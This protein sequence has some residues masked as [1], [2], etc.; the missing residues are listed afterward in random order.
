MTD[1][2]FTAKVEIFLH[3]RRH[4]G[5]E[6]TFASHFVEP[7]DFAPKQTGERVFFGIAT[8]KNVWLPHRHVELSAANPDAIMATVVLLFHQQEQ[9]LKAPKA[10]SITILIV[11]QRL[12]QADGGNATL[13][14]QK[15]AHGKEG[16]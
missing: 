8:A 1:E 3:T 15:I 9:L 4:F 14:F 10:G 16:L 7:L 6:Y 5:I 11:F 2:N 12:P 13:V